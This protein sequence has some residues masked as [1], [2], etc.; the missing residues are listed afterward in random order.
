MGR[1]GALFGQKALLFH[2]YI[3]ND[4]VN[5][6]QK[7]LSKAPFDDVYVNVNIDIKYLWKLPFVLW[8][9]GR[10]QKL[11]RLTVTINKWKI[12]EVPGFEKLRSAIREKD[13]AIVSYM[14]AKG[15]TKPQNSCIRDWV[16][17][18]RYFIVD[19]MDLCI[20]A[21]EKGYKLYGVNLGEY[22]KGDHRNGPYKYSNF[23]Y[24]G[25]FV[26]VNMVLLRDKFFST[27]VDQDYFGIEGFWGKLCPTDQAFCV[28]SSNGKDHYHEPYPEY[29]YK[30]PP[31]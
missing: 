21:F 30:K 28:H 26:S 22:K 11:Q 10:H 27:E 23:H 4:W 14:H 29:L 6:S 9:F 17:L 12:G 13:Y 25:N 16:E 15:V 7:L 20:D 5:T 24:S 1:C 2:V 18:M 31:Q 19:R 3:F 8:W